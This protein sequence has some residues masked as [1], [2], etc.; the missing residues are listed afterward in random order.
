MACPQIRTGERYLETMLTHIDCQAQTIGSLGYGALS[1]PGSAISIALTGILI[2]FVALFGIRIALGYPLASRTLADHA[3][4]LVIVLT[5]ATSWPAW[6]VLGYDLVI[7]GPAEVV[8]L[9]A[10]SSD[11]SGAGP[12]LTGRLQTVDDG[13]AILNERGAGRRGVQTG[14]W[15]QL[16]FA[17]SAFLTGTIGPIALIR[18]TGGILL[19]LAPLVAGLLLFGF[20]RSIFAGWA[21][22]L[23]AVFLATI[24]VTLLLSVEVALL[25]PWLQQVVALRAANQQALAAPTEALSIT[26]AFALM[27]FGAIAFAAWIAFNAPYRAI[28]TLR[29]PREVHDRT[30]RNQTTDTSRERFTERTFHGQAVAEQVARSMERDVRLGRTAQPAAAPSGAPQRVPQSTPTQEPARAATAIPLGSSY[31]RSAMPVLRSATRR[32]G[33]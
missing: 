9:V 24:S 1:E 2:I 17:R 18:L 33:A 28:A 22:A 29:Q 4:R 23:V 27:S 16:G 19:A 10:G 26:L 31:R 32:D 14:D 11:L 25:E 12:Q 20:T 5:L 21:K 13:F 6:R 15:F 3:I 8:Q 30:S 7:S